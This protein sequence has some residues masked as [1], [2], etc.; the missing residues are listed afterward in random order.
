MYCTNVRQKIQA[1]AAWLW[2]RLL[3]RW[4]HSLRR[5]CDRTA[6]IESAPRILQHHSRRM[7]PWLLTPANGLALQRKSSADVH[8]GTERPRC[9]LPQ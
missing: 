2:Q 1:A 5:V 6:G 7:F 9:C 3:L 8:V 4:E